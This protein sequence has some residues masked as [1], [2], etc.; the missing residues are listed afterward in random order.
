MHLQ[1]IQILFKVYKCWANTKCI[2][3]PKTIK[4]NEQTEDV[5]EA[6]KLT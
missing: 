3:V 4:I 1:S 6:N 5:F 2:T